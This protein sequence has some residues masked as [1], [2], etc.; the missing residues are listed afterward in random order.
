MPMRADIRT[1]QQ[2]PVPKRDQSQQQEGVKAAKAGA[3]EINAEANNRRDITAEKV[4]ILP[5]ATTVKSKGTGSR[6]RKR[7]QI[8]QLSKSRAVN[9]RAAEANAK[10]A[11]DVTEQQTRKKVYPR[12]TVISRANANQL[13]MRRA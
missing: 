1:K 8:Q 6:V 11:T 12:A 10:G 4:E 13:Q 2:R 9:A 7:V 5:K 3:A